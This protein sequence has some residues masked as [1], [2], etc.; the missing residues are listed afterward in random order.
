MTNLGD[1]SLD[2]R[3]AKQKRFPPDTLVILLSFFSY[4]KK[5]VSEQATRQLMNSSFY[6]I[7]SGLLAFDKTYIDNI[8]IK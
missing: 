2:V 1:E 5:K 3:D 6:L 8:L 7:T 4:T